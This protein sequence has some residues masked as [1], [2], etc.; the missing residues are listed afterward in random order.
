MNNGGQQFAVKA[1]FVEPAGTHQVAF[2][3]AG[4]RAALAH[5]RHAVFHH[6]RRL[7]DA[8]ALVVDGT[9]PVD[10]VQKPPEQLP[11]DAFH[12]FVADEER[13]LEQKARD[14]IAPFQVHEILAL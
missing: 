4:I 7:V 11:A 5:V 1:V 6:V 10:G 8:D 13:E 12:R 14:R 2:P 9:E 3:D